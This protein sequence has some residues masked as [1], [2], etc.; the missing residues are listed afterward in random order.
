[1]EFQDKEQ[2]KRDKYETDD[3]GRD[4]NPLLTGRN[5]KQSEIGHR[6]IGNLGQHADTWDTAD[7]DWIQ[8]KESRLKTTYGTH[9]RDY[10]ACI[11]GILRHA[12]RRRVK[13]AC[14]V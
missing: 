10:G 8:I 7:F 2:F 12:R 3:D 13:A 5:R 1:M 4:E 11:K 6:S 14:S 9:S